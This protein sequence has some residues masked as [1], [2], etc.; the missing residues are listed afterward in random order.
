MARS[1]VDGATESV[2]VWPDH[3]QH[4]YGKPG[5]ELFLVYHGV[6]EREIAAVKWGQAAFALVVEPPLI[7]LLFR[8]GNGIPWSVAPCRWH[9][10]PSAQ[11]FQSSWAVS[12]PGE[13]VCVR[14]TLIDADTCRLCA[15]RTEPLSPILTRAWNAAIRRQASRSCSEGR[16]SAALA[17]F[18]RR[19]PH[20]RSLLSQALAT[21]MG[22]E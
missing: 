1:F 19:F 16:Y 3:A 12:A 22:S 8:F 14:A 6:T 11:R 17:Q 15:V 2:A 18:A 7:M 13:H 5:Q 4:A 9:K 20:A 21:S 10:I